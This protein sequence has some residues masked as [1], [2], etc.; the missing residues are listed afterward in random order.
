[1]VEYERSCSWMPLPAFLTVQGV[2]RPVAQGALV[3]GRVYCGTPG[4]ASLVC[5]PSPPPPSSSPP[6]LLWWPPYGAI[7]RNHNT[8]EATTRFQDLRNAYEMLNY[9]ATKR[10]YDT[11]LGL[12]VVAGGDALWDDVLGVEDLQG[13]GFIHHRL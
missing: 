4:P 9:S 5:C 13:G 1:M 7:G 10:E 12:L 3:V 8:E 6:S 11:R 2:Q